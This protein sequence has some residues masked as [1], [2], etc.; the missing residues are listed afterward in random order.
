[1]PPR[2]LRYDWAY[3][4]VVPSVEDAARDGVESFGRRLFPGSLF[5]VGAFHEPTDLPLYPVPEVKVVGLETAHLS[6]D[7]RASV[8]DDRQPLGARIV[9]KE[10]CQHGC[11]I[12]TH[13]RKVKAGGG[14]GGG[15]GADRREAPRSVRPLCHLRRFRG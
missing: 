2:L 10:P 15:R 9:P 1:M 13:L 4:T 5:P 3:G 14:L 12:M 6:L 8:F 11:I 7:C